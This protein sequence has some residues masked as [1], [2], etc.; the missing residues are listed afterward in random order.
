[1]PSAIAEHVGNCGLEV[2]ANVLANE[3]EHAAGVATRHES[4]LH[5]HDTVVGIDLHQTQAQQL[6]EQFKRLFVRVAP[7][8]PKASRDKSAETYLLGRG[9]KA[10]PADGAE[11]NV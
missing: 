1:M 3:A 6:V 7:R 2:I 11:G 10:R 9:L 5:K 4:V 8:K